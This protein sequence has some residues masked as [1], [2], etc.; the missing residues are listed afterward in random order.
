MTTSLQNSDPKTTFGPPRPMSPVI[1]DD[2]KD[3]F[4]LVELLW[5]MSPRELK[6]AMIIRD[7]KAMQIS[8]IFLLHPPKGVKL[9]N[10]L[11]H[12]LNIRKYSSRS[13]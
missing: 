4:T 8:R 12:R 13:Y 2:L 11:M 6:K 1:E 10:L 3:Y 5:K 9:F 7:G